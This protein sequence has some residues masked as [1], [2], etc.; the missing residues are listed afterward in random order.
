VD[1]FGNFVAVE[2][3][4]SLLSDE[5]EVL[6]VLILLMCVV[7]SFVSFVMFYMSLEDVSIGRSRF[8]LLA[9]GTG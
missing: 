1:F 2:S 3:D 4:V 7:R 6:V 9:C 5:V 8:M